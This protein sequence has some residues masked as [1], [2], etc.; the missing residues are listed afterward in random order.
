MLSFGQG[1]SSPLKPDVANLSNCGSIRILV[2]F[3]MGQL[4]K[5]PGLGI[6]MIEEWV[7]LWG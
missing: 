7:V 5:D 2:C 4:V 3:R 6:D 1:C